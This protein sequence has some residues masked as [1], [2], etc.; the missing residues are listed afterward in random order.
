[1]LPQ[2]L[3]IT[4]IRSLGFRLYKCAEGL[5]TSLYRLSRDL[6]FIGLGC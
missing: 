6:G 4:R 3:M 1:M 5:H 2:L